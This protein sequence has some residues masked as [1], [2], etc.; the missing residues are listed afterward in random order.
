[1]YGRLGIQYNNAAAFS[2]I[3]SHMRDSDLKPGRIG[4]KSVTTELSRAL[5]CMVF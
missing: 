1:M 5:A 3:P 2:S 4:E